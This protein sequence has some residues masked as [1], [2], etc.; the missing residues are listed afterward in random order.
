MNVPFLQ[1][2]FL[3]SGPPAPPTR[4][5]T[6]LT[7]LSVTE[8]SVLPPRVKIDEYGGAGEVLAQ[9][10]MGL[11]ISASAGD[12]DGLR[13]NLVRAQAAHDGAMGPAGAG[14]GA[15]ISFFVFA[16]VMAAL[17]A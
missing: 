14:D 9:V 8:S 13:A 7:V 15:G 11:G 6:L 12:I 5:V 3:K 2:K 10:L 1:V 16:S 4:T 17:R